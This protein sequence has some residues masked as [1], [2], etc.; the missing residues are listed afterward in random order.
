MYH[1]YEALLSQ[2]REPVDRHCGIEGT[3]TAFSEVKEF[4]NEQLRRFR[5]LCSSLEGEGVGLGKKHAASTTALFRLPDAFLDMLRPDA[6]IYGV[7]NYL[8]Q[9]A[10]HLMDL[11]TALS[12]KARVI[13]VKQLDERESAGYGQAYVAKSKVRLGVALRRCRRRAGRSREG[14]RVRIGGGL[15][16]VVALSPSH[17][18]VEVQNHF[19]WCLTC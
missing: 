5:A 19:C 16:P 7:H 11:R 12:L 3:M 14:A 10:I 18:I 6:A 9:R 15:Y 1:L 4:D 2:D 8:E 17:T 13:Y